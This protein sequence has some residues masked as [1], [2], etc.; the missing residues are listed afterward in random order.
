M[1]DFIPGLEICGLFYEEC[2]KPI[3]ATHYPELQYSAA[4]IGYGSEVLGYDTQESTDHFWAPRVNLFLTEEDFVRLAKELNELLR[5]KLPPNFRGYSTN[6]VYLP[7][8][9][10]K[11]SVEIDSGPVNHLVSIETLRSRLSHTLGNALD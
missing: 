7:G 9:D 6:M 5:H 4:L 1:P 8:S 10:S 3:L 2:V 11:I